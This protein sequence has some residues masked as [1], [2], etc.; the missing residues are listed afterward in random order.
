MVKKKISKQELIN[1]VKSLYKNAGSIPQK[2]DDN[3]LNY[4]AKKVFG[5]WNKLIQ[6]AGFDVKFYQKI[7]CIR[8]DEN[9][10]Y[11]IG[12]L[13]TDGHIVYDSTNKKYKANLY[14]SYPEEKNMI[15]NLIKNY[16]LT[17]RV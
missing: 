9:F 7:T 5:S 14:T 3:N 16:F 11:F 1:I 4:Y 17:L 15:F 2:R 12:L 13:V 6:A 8:V 10:A